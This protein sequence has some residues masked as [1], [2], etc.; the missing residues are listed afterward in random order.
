MKVK[1]ESLDLYEIDRREL[2]RLAEDMHPK[3]ELVSMKLCLCSNLVG[4]SSTGWVVEIANLPGSDGWA[5]I[6][7]SQASRRPRPPV[8][9]CSM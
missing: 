3:V 6:S 2:K 7:Q 5:L 4:K 8:Q 1:K 9:C